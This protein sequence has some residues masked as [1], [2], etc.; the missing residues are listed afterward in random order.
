VGWVERNDTHHAV[1]AFAHDGFATLNR[2]L[3]NRSTRDLDMTL[4]FPSP[5]AGLFGRRLRSERGARIPVIVVS[6]FLGSGK[7]TLVKNL[8]SRPEGGGTAV[9][10]NEFGAVGIDDA[11]LRSSA[12]ETV[13]L[14]N[15]CLCCN[16][17]SDLQVA[18]RRLV[19]ERERGA[20]SHFQRIVIETSGLADLG[21]I[22]TTFATDRALAGEF[23]V[24]AVITVVDALCGG[25]TLATYGEARR[26]AILADRLVLTKSDI[27]DASA[28]DRLTAHL[29]ALNPRAEIAKADHGAIDPAFITTPAIIARAAGEFLAEAAHSDGI[30]SFV[31]IDDQPVR[32]EVFARLI[33]TLIALRGADL[34]RA[35]G[36]VNVAGARGPVV[37]NVVGHAA[38]PPI[39]LSAWADDERVSRVVFITRGIGERQVRD[40]L[41][42]L[43]GLSRTP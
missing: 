39:E 9:V 14:G 31:L 17:R 23:H 1:A 30:A 25:E 18:L 33:E 11:L 27:A 15:G 10:V 20:I 22:L 8:L 41:A 12:E 5:A 13:L 16:T 35:K 2:I 19:A 7:T 40:L 37:V 6:G 34:L 32:W 29:R 43:R 3:R 4:P 36:F 24:E 38:H 26:Q 42:A 28:V 21:P